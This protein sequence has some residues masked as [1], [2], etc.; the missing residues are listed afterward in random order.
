MTKYYLHGWGISIR[1]EENENLFRELL[2]GNLVH[3]NILIVLFA[4]EKSRWDEKYLETVTRFQNVSGE[5]IL[6]FECA[7]ED[8]LVLQNQ[9]KRSDIIFI[10]GGDTQML[11][12]KFEKIPDLEML[13]ENKIIAWSSAWSLFLMEWYYENDTHTYHAWLS[14]IEAKCICHWKDQWNELE[15]L[16]K[17]GEVNQEILLIPEW[18]YIIK[19]K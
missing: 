6:H 9:I 16:K 1:S 8:P 18:S 3:T 7:Q 11:Q 14:L 12:N 15:I 2:D 19:E 17:Y 13:F 4:R 5:K 10:H